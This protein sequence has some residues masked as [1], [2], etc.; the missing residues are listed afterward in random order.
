MALQNAASMSAW[1][2]GAEL[3]AL[4][5]VVT[6]LEGL[7]GLVAGAAG[8]AAAGPAFTGITTPRTFTLHDRQVRQEGCLAAAATPQSG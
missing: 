8:G 1:V 5:G 3:P 4:P 6:G 2:H 7:P